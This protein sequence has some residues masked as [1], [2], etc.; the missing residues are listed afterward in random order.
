L[1]I[2]TGVALYNFRAEDREVFNAGLAYKHLD[3]LEERRRTQPEPGWEEV[4]LSCSLHDLHEHTA[5]TGIF[6]K[7]SKP[8]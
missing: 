6:K 4:M 8:A 7:L 1:Y 5:K 3:L 2:G